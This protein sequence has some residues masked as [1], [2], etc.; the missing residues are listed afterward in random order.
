MLRRSRKFLV[1]LIASLA[2]VGCGATDDHATGAIEKKYA[3]PGSQAVTVALSYK[4]CDRRGNRYDLYYPTNLAA[5]A[6]HP[7]LTWGN[8]T[9]GVSSGAL[10]FLR[11][12]ASW[13]FVVVATRDRFTGDGTDLVARIG[14]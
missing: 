1:C 14:R 2:L 6:P 11:H 12:L 13:G 5:G 3:A 8:G 4:C 10:Y 7:I 9:G